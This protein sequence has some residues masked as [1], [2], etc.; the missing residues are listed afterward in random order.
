[1]NID[2]Q[3][4]NKKYNV[5]GFIYDRQLFLSR[6]FGL[7]STRLDEIS[8]IRLVKKKDVNVNFFFIA[9]SFISIF[10]SN[11]EIISF[12]IN[13]LLKVLAIILFI[14]AF[15]YKK[16]CYKIVVVTKSFAIIS[17][18]CDATSKNEALELVRNVNDELGK[19]H[20]FENAC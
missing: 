17:S 16:N 13:M 4:E 14:G 8:S 20:R 19:I 15:A 6:D 2:V 1:M 11:A 9:L 12:T 10:I 7:F 5:C 3:P 18:G